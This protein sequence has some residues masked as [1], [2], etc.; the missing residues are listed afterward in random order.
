[1]AFSKM[2]LFGEKMAKYRVFPFL[3]DFGPFWPFGPKPVNYMP[4]IRCKLVK[5]TGHHPS[6]HPK[7][8][9]VFHRFGPKWPNW[10]KITQK[11]KYPVLGGFF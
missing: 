2:A 7:G 11:W 1:M 4:P 3:S 8:G 6:L 5:K 9:Q 10:P